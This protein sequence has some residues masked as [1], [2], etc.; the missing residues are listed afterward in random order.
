MQPIVYASGGLLGDFIHQLSVINE[1]Y[2]KTGRKGIL[3]IV[4]WLSDPF[5]FGIEQAFHDT[6]PFVIKQEYI[7]DYQIYN[8]QYYEVLLSD[9]RLDSIVDNALQHWRDPTYDQAT[10]Y[11]IFKNKFNIEWGL[12]PWIKIDKI[13][14]EFTNKIIVCCS[15][16][17]HRIDFSINYK[18]LFEKYGEDNVVF[19][20]QN[21]QEYDHFVSFSKTNPKL[22]TPDTL[23]DFAIAINS[24][25]AFIGNLSMPL[26]LA[27]AMHKKS[28]IIVPPESFEVALVRNIHKYLPFVSYAK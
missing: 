10:T 21:K 26:T 27:F 28:I 17:K 18:G 1:T 24:A 15:L 25:E 22:Y 14:P 12:H 7:Q 13:N 5:K 16:E 9:W 6:Y 11:H 3:Y 20:T 8:G 23:E 19:V 2:I 4:N